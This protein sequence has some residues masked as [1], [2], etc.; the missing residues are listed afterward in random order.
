MR[1]ATACES[2]VWVGGFVS[3][4]VQGEIGLAGIR[5]MCWGNS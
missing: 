3:G 5:T 2:L 1:R 4:F